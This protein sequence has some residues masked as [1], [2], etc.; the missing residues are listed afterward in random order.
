MNQKESELMSSEWMNNS[1]LNEKNDSVWD[2]ILGNLNNLND[3][4]RMNYNSDMKEF[5][6]NF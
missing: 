4:I 5:N 2:E 6:T 3:W 1:D